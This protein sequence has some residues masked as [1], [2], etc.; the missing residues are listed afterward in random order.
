MPAIPTFSNTMFVPAGPGPALAEP[1]VFSQPGAALEQAGAQASAPFQAWA[2][3]FGEAKRQSDA[4]NLVATGYQQLGDARIK[5]SLIPDPMQ[6]MAQYQAEAAKITKATLAQTA[7]PLVQNYVG[8]RMA[9]QTAVD[10]QAVHQGAFRQWQTQQGGDLQ[11]RL[12]TFQQQYALAPTPA[13]RANVLDQIH[14]DI[15]GVVAA[16]GIDPGQG[17]A[18]ELNARQNAD[19]A[20]AKEFAVQNPIQ[21]E[22]VLQD[23]KRYLALFPNLTPNAAGSLAQTTMFKAWHEEGMAAAAQAHADMTAAREVRETQTI[24][25]TRLLT[26]VLSGQITSMAPALDAANHFLLSPS[27][28]D[29]IQTALIRKGAGQ[30]DPAVALP[31]IQKLGNGTLEW[32]DVSAAAAAGHLS[33]ATALSLGNALNAHAKDASSRAL[34]EGLQM[35]HIGMGG[36]AL[37]AG[38]TMVPGQTVA[39]GQANLALA[40]QELIRRV[41]NGENGIAVATDILAREAPKLP[42]PTMGVLRDGAT[43]VEIV[44][45]YAKE[46]AA[47]AAGTLPPQQFYRDQLIFNE[48]LER[49]ALKQ[50][51]APL[52]PVPPRWVP[53]PAIPAAIG[54]DTGAL[55]EGG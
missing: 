44:Q 40:S 33:T 3:Q 46:K 23:P 37:D 7:D 55:N 11:A 30:T 24:T 9:M 16:H 41:N 39:Q 17:A 19:L 47:M 53:P 28:L 38:M 4:A 22:Q 52:L 50:A 32:S 29:A 26:G 34:S 2:A 8:A 21:A 18:L 43:A 27:G 10:N 42:Q 1:G 14:Q 5:A 31:L 15:A 45:L 20:A 35:V 13:A 54:A 48:H 6:A 25:E 49:A 51:T 36:K 12:V